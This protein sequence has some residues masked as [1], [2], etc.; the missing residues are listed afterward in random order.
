MVRTA[1]SQ[2]R[3]LALQTGRP[4]GS[5]PRR[6]THYATLPGLPPYRYVLSMSSNLY[7]RN[8]STLRGRLVGGGQA[9][10]PPAC[11]NAARFQWS[12][13]YAGQDKRHSDSRSHLRLVSGPLLILSASHSVWAG[14]ICL[15]ACPSVWSRKVPA[16]PFHSTQFSSIRFPCN[17][18][19]IPSPSTRG[20]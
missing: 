7:E 10:V 12:A 17:A 20:P 8:F 15:Y 4:R 18:V 1:T 11:T 16:Y 6:L 2:C 14:P 13:N 9:A 5:K 3:W 19:C